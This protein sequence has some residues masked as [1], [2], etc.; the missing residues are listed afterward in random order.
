MRLDLTARKEKY[1]DLTLL[2][3]STIQIKKPSEQMIIDLDDY[4]VE[5]RKTTDSKKAIKVVKEMTC[6]ILNCNV[7]MRNFTVQY[8]EEN[9]YDYEICGAIISTYEKFLSEI[10][11]NPN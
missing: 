11:S 2:D 8:L 10:M 9:G 6:K 4:K 1:F 5:V 3:G 7:G